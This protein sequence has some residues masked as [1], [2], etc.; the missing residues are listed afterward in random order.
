M[1]S[2]LHSQ[3]SNTKKRESVNC[4]S[5]RASILKSFNL[6][7]CWK[8]KEVLV[9]ALCDKKKFLPSFFLPFYLLVFYLPSSVVLLKAFQ[10]P[11]IRRMTI[12]NAKIMAI[13]NCYRFFEMIGECV[14]VIESRHGHLQCLMK[15]KVENLL[16]I[17]INNRL[18]ITQHKNNIFIT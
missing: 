15:R 1:P 7:Q 8:V 14:E 13:L 16:K 10:H 11:V 9:S 6:I 12:F 4:Y 5:T 3:S 2:S 17:K 18:L